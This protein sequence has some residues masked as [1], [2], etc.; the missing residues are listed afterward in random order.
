MRSR[1]LAIVL[2][3]IAGFTERTGRQ[4]R[5]QNEAWL[6]RYRNLM[7]PLV[8]ALG[9]RRIKSI[10]DAYLCAFD[11]PTNALFFG[12]A[13]HDRIFEFNQGAMEEERFSIRVAVSAG[14]VRLQGGDIFGE[15][16]NLAARV[17]GITPAGEIWFTEAVFLAMTRSE[18]PSEEVGVHEFKGISQ[19]VRV[20]R[21]IR[22]SLSQSPEPAPTAPGEEQA[23]AHPFGG[24]GLRKARQSPL[25]LAAGGISSSLSEAT[26]RLGEIAGN[27]LVHLGE[28]LGRLR[29]RVPRAAWLAG[30]VVLA[31]VAAILLMRSP[32][33][34]AEARR[35]LANGKP[36]HALT[37]L[38][39]QS[40]PEDPIWQAL[41]A[42]A[43]LQK[44]RPDPAGA[45]RLLQSACTQEAR[46][47]ADDDV[48]SDLVSSLN[49][50]PADETIDFIAQ[51]A[52]EAA[53]PALKQAAGDRRY[54]LRWNS[55][56]ALKKLGRDDDIDLAALYILDLEHVDACSV[57]K[58]AAKKLGELKDPRA[59]EPLRRAA[60]R[61]V[62]DN[63][64]MFGTLEEA[65]AAIEATQR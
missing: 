61:S 32:A 52:G 43:L 37:L 13:A 8:K 33:P 24:A 57:R 34:F 18:I 15:P 56:R 48:I 28:R 1:N 31:I 6:R 2:V 65:I 42:R 60:Q 41:K 64:C 63:L 50:H 30:A 55:V 9:G 40:R 19:P 25:S 21:V 3:D 22:P 49:R 27:S 46:L 38:T 36:E 12:M 39:R 23:A 35:A 44:P 45:A 10:G 16:V 29:A 17:E 54:S 58:A 4:S 7:L 51:R 5:E 14:E 11:S 62:L 20:F 26:A 59:L 47:L 53:V